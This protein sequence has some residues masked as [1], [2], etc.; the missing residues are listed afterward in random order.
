MCGSATILTEAGLLAQ[1]IAPGL[2]HQGKFG[3]ENW[4][5]FDSELWTQVRE[6]AKAQRLEEP[7]A[8]IAGSDLDPK[9]IDMAASNIT[10]AGLEDCIRLSVRD[11]KDATP[12][13]TRS[14]ASSSPTRPT[15]SE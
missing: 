6:E 15:A 13:K 3:F 11:V 14:P 12:P 9:V 2:F 8:Y 5:D 7:Q 4:Y 1:R 10:A